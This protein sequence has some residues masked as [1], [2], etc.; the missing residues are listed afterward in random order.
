MRHQVL[1][2]PLPWRRQLRNAVRNLGRRARRWC[3]CRDVVVLPCNGGRD[4]IWV[5]RGCEAAVQRD[6]D[7]RI[8]R[9][10]VAVVERRA[11][12]Q[13]SG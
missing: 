12:A 13:R 8:A 6:A 3:A 7:S 4:V 9:R 5:C 10:K 11:E 1:G 2:Q